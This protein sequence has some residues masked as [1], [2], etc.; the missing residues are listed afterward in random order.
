M[1]AALTIIAWIGAVAITLG[2]AYVVSLLL[3]LPVRAWGRGEHRKA[4]LVG[5]AVTLVFLVWFA[6]SQVA[7]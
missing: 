6:G 4:V 5:I 7:P 3:R 2:V 1:E